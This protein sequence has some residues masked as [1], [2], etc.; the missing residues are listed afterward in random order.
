MNHIA[1][2]DSLRENFL[3]DYILNVI[4]FKCSKEVKNNERDARKINIDRRRWKGRTK[5]VT[6]VE[7]RMDVRT[8]EK[9]LPKYL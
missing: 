8:F 6:N 3:N 5:Y 2:V 7:K 1:N 9:R 4:I